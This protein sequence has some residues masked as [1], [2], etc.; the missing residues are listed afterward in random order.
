MIG[1]LRRPER[2]RQGVVL[3]ED[4]PGVVGVGRLDLYDHTG[5][6]VDHDRAALDLVVERRLDPVRR[7][8]RLG[9]LGLAGGGERRHGD[10]LG[11]LIGVGAA[12]PRSV[13]QRALLDASKPP[14]VDACQV[15]VRECGN[16]GSVD[17]NR[18]LDAA[19]Q[20]ATEHGID[21]LTLA[22]VGARAGVSRQAVYLH[23]GNRATLLVEMAARVD[24]TS[25][26]R[27]G[28][29]ATRHLAPRE[30]FRRMLDLWFDYIPSMLASSSPS[31][32]PPHRRRRC[33]R[34]S[35]PDERVARRHPDL[36]RPPRRRRRVVAAVGRRHGDGL[37]VGRAWPIRPASTT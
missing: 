31:R 4:A 11:V 18:L 12:H 1:G 24:H 5:L 14:S 8:L 16:A 26:F 22:T 21:R 28:L 23:F 34:L 35:R 7:Q 15:G 17:P 29:A 20:E 25:G 33:R 9:D 37:D 19:W 6:A 2:R 27:S 3:A 32:R 10:R 30:G 13:K 36:D